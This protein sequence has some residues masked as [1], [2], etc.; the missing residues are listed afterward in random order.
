[1]LL[2]STASFSGICSY[3]LCTGSPFWTCPILNYKVLP[4]SLMMEYLPSC[5]VL[6]HTC[7][8]SLWKFYSHLQAYLAGFHVIHNSFLPAFLCHV[9]GECLCLFCH[10]AK[11]TFH[12]C[13]IIFPTSLILSDQIPPFICIRRKRE[14]RKRTSEW[15]KVV[16]N[17][18]SKQGSVLHVHPKIVIIQK[19]FYRCFFTNSTF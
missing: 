17:H 7:S 3:T 6:L 5:A 11:K 4:H 12:F 9:L 18:K 8:V 13:C 16:G 1:M 14:G 19:Q 15:K 2:H 10:P